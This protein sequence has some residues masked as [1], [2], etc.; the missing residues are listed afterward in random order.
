[1]GLEGAHPGITF[2]VALEPGEA[3]EGVGYLVLADGLEQARLYRSLADVGD[4][5]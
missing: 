5:A 3:L 4:L 2:R 1:M